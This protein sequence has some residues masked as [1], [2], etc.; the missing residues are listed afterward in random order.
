MV[1]SMSLKLCLTVSDSLPLT[2][3]CELL[4]TNHACTIDDIIGAAAGRLVAPKE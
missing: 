4:P 1:N 2:T 3:G